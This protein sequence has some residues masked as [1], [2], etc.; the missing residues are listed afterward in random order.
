MYTALQGLPIG[1]TAVGGRPGTAS[2]ENCRKDVSCATAEE[3]RA[4]VPDGRRK[5]ALE[6]IVLKAGVA[7]PDGMRG[8]AVAVWSEEV[9]R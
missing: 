2:L 8:N 6:T 9:L 4:S 3:G 1:T 7:A 5:P